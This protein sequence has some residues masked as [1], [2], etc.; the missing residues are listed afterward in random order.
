M[1]F[2]PA[3]HAGA[4][5]RSL[6]NSTR[7]GLD[8][9]VLV[10]ERTFSASIDDVWDALTTPER[11]H[12]WMAPISGDLQLGG[13]Y[14]VEGN[15]GGEVLACEPPKHFSISWVFGGDTSWV[16]VYLEPAGDGTE[17]RLEHSASLEGL[18][19]EHYLQFGPGATGMGW[20][21][22]LMGLA[23]H[24]ETPDLVIREG[25]AATIDLSGFMASS[26]NGWR[27]AAIEIGEDP[28]Q[29]TAAAERCL[30]AYT[31]G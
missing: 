12:R 15:A 10:A 14:Q 22:S 16:D 6:T 13:H 29:A 24:F 20:E 30:A 3:E 25:D 23:E 1:K 26:S 21:L 7:D 2:S 4:V 5:T 11:I 31:G 18:T 8:V 27:E 19:S 9:R 28:E 17:L